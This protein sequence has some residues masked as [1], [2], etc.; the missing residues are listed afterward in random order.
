MQQK[1]QSMACQTLFQRVE[2]CMENLEM[3]NALRKIESFSV[4]DAKVEAVQ[5]MVE[6][7]ERKQMFEALI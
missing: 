5:C 4:S 7:Q 2:F 1:I 3:R 6:I